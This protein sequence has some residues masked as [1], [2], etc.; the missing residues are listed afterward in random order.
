MRGKKV[1]ITGANSS[2]G[3]AAAVQIAQ[4]GATVIMACRSFDRGSKALLEFRTQSG[5]QDVKLLVVDTSSLE[6]IRGSVKLHSLRFSRY[7]IL[8]HIPFDFDEYY[9]ACFGIHYNN[10]R[11][12]GFA[13]G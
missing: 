11:D 12:I 5:S 10:V 2:I 3:N 4:L 9:L 6:S 1:I 8:A 7:L 13:I